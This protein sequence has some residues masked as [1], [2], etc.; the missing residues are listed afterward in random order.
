MLFGLTFQL[1]KLVDNNLKCQ[2]PGH[3]ESFSTAIVHAPENDASERSKS[4]VSRH[5]GKQ[6]LEIG[7]TRVTNVSDLAVGEHGT[8]NRPPESG[9]VTK[10][11]LPLQFL[12]VVFIHVSFSARQG[13]SSWEKGIALLFFWRRTRHSKFRKISQD[14]PAK[15]SHY[16]LAC[17]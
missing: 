17:R 4:V 12:S 5:Q 6:M 3:T 9:A 10:G 14:V 15:C 8:Q 1:S 11:I 7:R 16:V 2:R 13:L